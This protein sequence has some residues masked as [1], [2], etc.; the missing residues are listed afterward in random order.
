V[1]KSVRFHKPPPKRTPLRVDG[2]ALEVRWSRRRRTLCLSVGREG[3]LVVYAPAGVPQKALEAFVRDRKPWI[4]GKLAKREALKRA[5]PRRTYVDGEMFPFLGS[6]YPL[7]LVE[8]QGAPL[9][10][11]EGGF[12]L[13]R[14]EARRGREHF[15]RWY[16]GRAGEWI[17]PHVEAF[18][19]RMGV[20]PSGIRIRDYRSRWGSCSPRGVLGFHWALILFPPAASGYVVVHELAHLAHRN[21]GPSFW[22]TVRSVLPDFGET[23]AWIARNGSA[24][25]G[26]L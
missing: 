14:S 19:A 1:L 10:W 8:E 11:G 16:A 25:A 5:F 24:W 4:R 15:V 7:H 12:S 20:A 22:R 26:M 23:R 9:L 13:L 2:L 21:H 3:E 6:S 17:A 18:A